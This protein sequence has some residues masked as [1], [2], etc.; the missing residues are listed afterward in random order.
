MRQFHTYIDTVFLYNS[1]I[2][3]TNNTINK[4]I[5]SFHR[6]VI[7][8]AIN[9]TWP[10]H[11]YTNQ[12]LYNITKTKPWSETIKIR[13]LNWTGHLLRLP[14]NTPARLALAE[15][16]QPQQRKAG[17]PPANWINCVKQQC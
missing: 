10:K 1:E 11:V 6:R 8:I 12:E 5:D 3:T 17:R 16:I 4:K 14:A 15:C 9:K 2:W 7:R 13:R